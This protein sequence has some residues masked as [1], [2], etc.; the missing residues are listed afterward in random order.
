MTVSA[1]KIESRKMSP[2]STVA[3]TLF[4]SAVVDENCFPQREINIV[5]AIGRKGGGKPRILPLFHRLTVRLTKKQKKTNNNNNDTIAGYWASRQ[6][7]GSNRFTACYNNVS[8]NRRQT[9]KFSR[10]TH[11][12]AL[13]YILLPTDLFKT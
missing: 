1:R 12:R 2:I 11:L 3:G 6:P 4:T 7:T 8:T 9:L 5:T 10:K 13:S